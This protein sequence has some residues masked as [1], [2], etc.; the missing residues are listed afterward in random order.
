MPRGAILLERKG[1]DEIEAL[2]F[3]LSKLGI[4]LAE[5][6]D[7]AILDLPSITVKGSISDPS[8]KVEVNGLEALVIGNQFEVRDFPLDIGENI[9]TATATN[10][11]QINASDTIQVIYEP[12][13]PPLTI[14]IQ[15]PGKGST[16][17]R[18]S[19]E[20]TG[21]MS[22]PEAKVFINGREAVVEGNIFRVSDLQLDFGENAITA[23]VMD[24]LGRTASDTVTVDYSWI[25]VLLTSPSDGEVLSVSSMDVLGRVNDSTALVD[26]N[27]KVATVQMDGS[28]SVNGLPLFEG[29]NEITAQ[30][31]NL[32]GQTNTDSIQVTYEP[33][34][35]PLTVS[36]LTPID[37]SNLETLRIKVV[38]IVSDPTVTLLV[39]DGL[40]RIQEDRFEATVDVCEEPIAAASLFRQATFHGN[41]WDC[42]ITV[43]AYS[44]DGETAVRNII[45]TH[46]SVQNPLT[47]SITD[48]LDDA[49]LTYSPIQITGEVNDVLSGLS[50][51][52]ITVN[53]VAATVQENEGS[54]FTA[55]VPLQDG[56]NDITTHAQDAVGGDAYDTLRIL[57]E[58]AT[59]P[60]SVLITSP[61]DSAIVN[62]ASIAISGL[63]SD[64][65]VSVQVNSVDADLDFRSFT[66]ASI[67]LTIGTNTLTATAQRPNGE[68]ATASVIVTYDPNYASPP[69]PLL[70]QLPEYV[71][72]SHLGISGLTLPLHSAEVFV[73]GSSRGVTP[74]DSQGLFSTTVLLS[75][76]I[77][78]LSARA[79][80]PFGNRS[81]LSIE[82]SVIRDTIK[83][84]IQQ[85]ILLIDRLNLAV[86]RVLIAGKTEA[87]ADV[88]IAIDDD[89][90][91]EVQMT[92]DDQGRFGTYTHLSAGN[93]QL[94]IRS[95]D[96]AGNV[97]T[98]F[99]NHTVHNRFSRRPLP[100][101]IDPMS[102]P[103]NETN[104]TIE[105][106][107]YANFLVEIYLN[108]QRMGTVL[109]DHR[110]RFVLENVSLIPG[111]NTLRVR[112]LSKQI[113]FNNRVLSLDEADSSEV[114]V[115]VISASPIRP[116]VTIGFPVNGAETD[117]AFVPLRGSVDTSGVTLRLNGYYN[118][119]GYAQEQQT[120]F[121]SNQKIPLL[122]GENTL[123]I[124]ASAPDGSRGVDKITVDSRRDA[125]VPTVQITAPVAG[126]EI[127]TSTII[128][129]G[130]IDATV[131]TV[132]VNETEAFLGNGTFQA[133]FIDILS[134]AYVSNPEGHPRLITAW[135]MDA[136]GQI[137][138][139]DVPV[140]YRFIPT[141]F[142]N[143]TLPIDGAIVTTPSVNVMGQVF[144][145][146]EVTVNGVPAEIDGNTFTAEINLEEGLNTINAI[147][148]NTIK[149]NAETIQITYQ[150][151]GPVVFQTIAM[152][153]TDATV[154][155]GGSVRLKAIGTYS[156]GNIVDLTL[157]SIWSSNDPTLATVKNGS[158]TA[159]ALGMT[160][161][162]AVSDGITGI[163]TL[164][165]GPPTLESLRVVYQGESGRLSSDPPTL[166][167]GE[168]LFFKA[169][170]TYSDNSVVD[171]TG[172]V[173]WASRDSTIATIDSSGMATGLS[174]GTSLV[175]ATDQTI[176]GSSTLTVEP[177]PLY[178]FINSPTGG[179]TINRENVM[180]RG[181]VFTGAEEVGITVNGVIANV[182]GNE[183]IVNGIFLVDGSNPIT[184]QAID[185]NGAQAQAQ[186]IV[187]AI[188]TDPQITL[189]SN[190]AS[191]IAPLDFNLRILST[192]NF[193]SSTLTYAGPG[194]ATI[195]AI[196][197]ENVM[198][199][200]TVFTGAEEVGITVNGV[201]A[202]VFG[203][204]FIV[205]GIFLVDGS[206]PIT[207]QAIDSNGAQA[208]AQVIV[209]AITTDPQITLTS[210]IASG[211]APLDF[212]LRILST[213]NFTSSTLTYAGPG[214]ATITAINEV[215]Y[216]VRVDS[217]GLYFFTAQVT[218]DQS[219]VH[220]DTIGITVLNLAEL[221]ALLQAKWEGIKQALI[222]LDIN[223]ALGN[224][225]EDSK[226][227][228]ESLF[229]RFGNNLSG[230]ATNLPDLQLI[231]IVSD[232]A[233]YYVI[234][235][236]NG[237][238]RTH[239]IYFARDTEGIW[240]LQTF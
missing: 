41:S 3:G 222:N 172:S 127:F 2:D 236:E 89:P 38:G 232:V 65:T 190:I 32:Q 205:N 126:E 123:W 26:V 40:A 46:T 191:G 54:A 11:A 73:N 174:E 149:A 55:S 81:P 31:T 124:E 197:R 120:T 217:E 140:R 167:P 161:I 28:F 186:V 150:P 22:D 158:V 227:K 63:V 143:I 29:R 69:A 5:P 68:T 64:S 108:D 200:G 62:V 157:D 122:P 130:T 97:A 229:N 223:G 176:I 125:V 132:I 121:K 92:A 198:V 58:P 27:G 1:F 168:T 195:T 71:R 163:A 39:N 164:T 184:A 152:D 53:G 44:D 86:S 137:G 18:A 35:V 214:A 9:I 100:P 57:Y 231:R 30:A 199:R 188:T 47:V 219:I 180:V 75:E 171:L 118:N 224:I 131:Q 233:S 45:Y 225:A 216:E 110:G 10:L 215:E 173:T 111:S 101:A 25:T 135:A 99:E 23:F 147:A 155:L 50:P 169:L 6:L 194:A 15:S 183:F 133:N 201:I 8:A 94:E 14:A 116:N 221:D 106:N 226:P 70:S 202:N 87:L 24:A 91:Y 207:A 145:A 160:T 240:K 128:P 212:N 104:V 77:N 34:P 96:L 67:P 141:P 177:P 4:S 60:L 52:V 112:Q 76:G 230:I 185:S 80:D 210:N 105:G 114:V 234:K 74:A 208:Q 218:D 237:V 142:T 33:P 56:V 166:S 204:E 84:Y 19:I 189:T 107:A 72:T 187:D 13:L 156:D 12:S 43:T 239:F 178:L 59:K 213:F 211:I 61:V 170:G 220:S 51:T 235:D 115:N 20:V 17:F 153:P 119:I 42:T 193:T 175:S 36:L 83:P 102:S 85:G 209:D 151:A 49:V 109:T 144:D 79:M 134:S 37:G 129:F 192:F 206:N 159:Q 103:T 88:L 182:F 7:G 66:H 238:N 138:H 117:A 162:T 95:V 228:Y 179:S 136:K 165:V 139:H 98:L 48:P 93:H 154:P 90:D 181:T 148:K 82:A 146:S 78:H 16:F 113:G 196:N 203:N 21:T